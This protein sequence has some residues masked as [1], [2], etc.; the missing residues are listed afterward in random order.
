MP[1]SRFVVVGMTRDE[2]A[3]LFG[4]KPEMLTPPPDK[5]F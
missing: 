1:K 2:D 4:R 5:G 3:T